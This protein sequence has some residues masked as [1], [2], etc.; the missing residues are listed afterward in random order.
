MP[1][2]ASMVCLIDSFCSAFCGAALMTR[3]ATS[4]S[5]NVKVHLDGIPLDL[6]SW[7][8][9]RYSKLLLLYA[10][11]HLHARSEEHL[12]VNR[13]PVKNGKAEECPAWDSG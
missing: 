5:V 1:K 9:P 13:K 4:D 8:L 10:H 3:M 6:T 11:I 7:M 12:N 2:R